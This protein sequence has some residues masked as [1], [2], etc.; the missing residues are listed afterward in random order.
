M[1]SIDQFVDSLYKGVDG[2]LEEI[3][4]FKEEMKAHLIETVKELKKEGRTEE[5]SLRIAYER[6][7]E[8][9]IIN[10]GL[11]NLFHKQKKF[12]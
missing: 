3:S 5:E 6:F 1:K 2:N 11:L 12:I 4:G 9:K 10:T 7:G 8:I